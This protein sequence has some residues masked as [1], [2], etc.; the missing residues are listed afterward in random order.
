MEERL[1]QRGQT[2][3]RADDNP[4]TIKKRF[5]TFQKETAPIVDKYEKDGIVLR[6]N[7]E[8]NK[9]E[10]FNDLKETLKANNYK[11]IKE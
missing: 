9:D 11:T 6:V 3:G 8:K 1:I 2:S 5:I 7:S 10:V 4:D